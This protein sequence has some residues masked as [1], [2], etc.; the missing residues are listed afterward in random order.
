MLRGIYAHLMMGRMRNLEFREML[1]VAPSICKV[2]WNQIEMFQ[3]GHVQR[4]IVDALMKRVENIIVK[5]KKVEKK[6]ENVGETNQ[7]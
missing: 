6:T 2:A 5:G 7:N 1:E 4:K 3:V